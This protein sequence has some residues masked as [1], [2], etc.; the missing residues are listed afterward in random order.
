MIKTLSQKKRMAFNL[1]LILIIGLFS[2][3]YVD[4]AGSKNLCKNP[5]F[6]ENISGWNYFSGTF[7]R[8]EE[9]AH[10]GVA[11]GKMVVTSMW[12]RAPYTYN[13]QKGVSYHVLL[14]VKLIKG[15]NGAEKSEACVILDHSSFG[16][17]GEPR[18]EIFAGGTTVN[19]GEWVELAFDYV[20]TGSNKT[21]GA[22]FYVRIGSGEKPCAYYIDDVSITS[23]GAG[24]YRDTEFKK[25][26]MV[27]NKGFDMDTEGWITN[28]AAITR[29]EDMGYNN[30]YASALITTEDYTG[31]AAQKLTLKNCEKY[32][33]S[34]YV[35]TLGEAA[36]FRFIVMRG[37]GS[38]EIPVYS[39]IVGSDWGKI[40]GEYVFYSGQDSEEVWVY[41]LT[42]NVKSYYLDDFSVVDTETAVPAFAETVNIPENLD[43]SLRIIV[44]GEIK[45]IT[46]AVLKNDTVVCAVQELTQALNGYCIYDSENRKMKAV[47]GLNEVELQAGMRCIGA[48]GIVSITDIC[49]YIENEKLYWSAKTLAEK[50]GCTGEWLPEKNTLSV[51]KPENSGLN[52]SA[53][54][55][56]KNKKLTI[57]YLRGSNPERGGTVDPYTVSMQ[58]LINQWFSSR[59][60]DCE[61]S[62]ADANVSGA[63]AL[64]G[65]FRGA[66]DMIE[67]GV[68]LV[69]VDFAQND[70]GQENLA[71]Y[72]ESTVRSLKALKPDIDIVFLYSLNKAIADKYESGVTPDII[73]EYDKIAANYHIPSIN[74]GKIL[75][76]KYTAK[77]KSFSDYM[78][79]V[80]NPNSS[81]AAVYAD[82]IIQFINK[83][84]SCAENYESSGL[85][86]SMS[87]KAFTGGLKN[88][89]KAV[90]DKNWRLENSRL[91]GSCLTQYIES[92]IPGAEMTFSFTGSMIGLYLQKSYD[93]GDIL[94][95]VDGG[96]YQTLSVFD[97]HSMEFEHA[98]GFILADGLGSGAHTLS[99]KVAGTKN[100]NSVDYYVRIG[101]FLTAYGEGI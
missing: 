64:L 54:C 53:A 94:W 17:S 69:F 47:R 92:N 98:A 46:T 27:S 79:P 1:I 74:I 95:S 78:N 80:S 25:G 8:S 13:F 29:V 89:D 9:T 93:C 7:S 81:G 63:G 70:I 15:E 49:P 36:D 18:W 4:A 38:Y 97:E 12:G 14:W 35:K 3:I 60:N 61:I 22:D 77:G 55:L 43:N 88:A 33:L 44:N 75:Y 19:T 23:D 20:Y 87:E 57:G 34:A 11:S 39:A 91:S 65:S 67:K 76:Q 51:T 82:S 68:D 96:K 10:S 73:S 101:A 42:N 90:T 66:E 2:S 24:N 31:Y 99:V 83:G 48:N 50:L 40:S 84:F 56:Q 5:G 72:I 41:L 6:E 71:V 32:E 52:Y 37:D 100:S 58:T 45:N 16:I 59:F 21:G 85:G 30:S 26:E 86:R 28:K 62:V